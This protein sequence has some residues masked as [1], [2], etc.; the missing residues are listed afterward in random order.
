[1]NDLAGYLAGQRWY[2][3]EG[4]PTRVE[5]FSAEQV[6]G[7]LASLIVDTDAGTFHVLDGPDDWAAV[8]A[9]TAPGEQAGNA[10]HMGVEQSNTSIVFDDRLVLKVFRRVHPGKN[11]EVEITAALARTGFESV[12]QPI[13]VWEFGGYTKGVVQPFLANGREGW[14]LA[15]ASPHF[16]GEAAELGAVTADMH[17]ALGDVFGARPG[18][19]EAWAAGIE[20]GLARLDAAAERPAAKAVVDR[21]RSATNPGP[22]QCVHGDYH[23]GQVMRT[24]ERWYVLDFEGE[25][26]R[27]HEERAEQTSPMKDVTGMLRSFGY[28]AAIGGKEPGWERDCRRAFLDAYAD[29]RPLPDQAVL[30]AFELDKAIYE[31]AYERSYRPQWAGVPLAAIERLLEAS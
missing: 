13:G 26:A 23:L 20:S 28:A 15:L 7:T 3:G 30:D 27:P 1:V 29:R 4:P 2:A 22:T 9:R 14:E 6:T 31:L 24:A 8:L 19:P 18:D 10:R 12:A 21:L 5:I 25:P 11:L 16:A 17:S